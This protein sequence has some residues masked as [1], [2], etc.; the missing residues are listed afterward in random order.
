MH[1]N[2]CLPILAM[3]SLCGAVQAAVTLTPL[4][5]FGTG[6]T[7][8]ASVSTPY[9]L[10]TG[11][12]ERS[13]GFNPLTGN[14]YVA[15]RQSGAAEI[16]ILNGTTGAE[17][18][19]LKSDA[20]TAS[21]GFHINCIAV[22][23]DGAIYADNVVTDDNTVLYDK[24]VHVYRFASE[25]D[26]RTSDP[27][28][29]FDSQ[30][31][32]GG[33]RWGD[34]F[35][36][37]GSGSNTQILIGAGTNLE[38]GLDPADNNSVVLMTVNDPTFGSSSSLT[39]NPSNI[40][41]LGDYRSGLAF[42]P[43]DSFFGKCGPQQT[44]IAAQNLAYATFD[45]TTYSATQ[46]TVTEPP[47]QLNISA[48]ATDNTNHLLAGLIGNQAAGDTAEVVLYDIS[49]PTAPQLLTTMPLVNTNANQYQV[50]GV[51]FGN[52]GTLYVL[53]TDN[54]IQA[55]QINGVPEPASIGMLAITSAFLL[56]RRAR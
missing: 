10:P 24:G 4:S 53:N 22:A 28:L 9:L 7:I 54:S 14:L 20:I 18:G 51:Q 44:S 16:Q 19:T 17:D 8:S 41:N 3:V 21:T 23:A 34:S 25:A 39:P 29:I 15:Y 12:N 46:Q 30:I 50:G 55:F 31:G 38:S 40:G 56:K 52:N 2:H 43:G 13:I 37:R 42:G 45:P 26:G 33:Q 36:V 6:G 5:S 49:D 47:D 35:A 48:I 32:R 27:S 1:R 11:D